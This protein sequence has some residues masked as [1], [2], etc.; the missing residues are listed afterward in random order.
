MNAAGGLFTTTAMADLFSPR[1]HV[2]QM[3]RFEAALARS[4]ARA[5]VIPEATASSIVAAC[6]VELYDAAPIYAA[7]AIH[8]ADAIYA[9][10]AIAG[11][12]VIPFVRMLADRVHFLGGP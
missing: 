6:R 12:P 7:D 1:A 3:I 5:G 10:A 11:T 9:A 4:A 8:A 2:S